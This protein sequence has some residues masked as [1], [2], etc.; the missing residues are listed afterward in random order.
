MVTIKDIARSAGVSHTTV[1]RALNDSP[2]IKN[3]TKKKIRE[4]AEQ[5]DYVPNLSA[6]GLVNQKKYLIGLFFSSI[7]QGTSSSFLADTIAGI[8]NALD[9]NYGLSV[10]SIDTLDQEKDAKLQR[11]DGVIVMSQSDEDQPFIDYLKQQAIPFVVVNRCI[12]DK[13]IY[14]VFANDAEGVTQA[15]DYA[16]RL[17]HKKI[18]YIGGKENF[19]STNERKKGVLESLRKAGL[20]IENDYFLTGD[21]S[22][23]SGLEQMN[24]LLSLPELPTLVF[25]GNDDMAIGALR[26]ITLAGFSVPQDISLIGFD[27]SPVVSY[28]NPPLT[29]VHKPLREISEQGTKMLLSLIQGTPPSKKKVQL[30][31]TLNIRQSVKEANSRS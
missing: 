18:A 26:S 24:Q 12:P 9:G 4:I 5:L 2:L 14:N 30:T 25:C 28:L 15:I 7:H 23:Q 8:R 31:T 6:K 13:S 10:E 27:D 16:I 29:T 17:G 20:L 19:R 3:E 1:S 22:L 21:Y 11:Y